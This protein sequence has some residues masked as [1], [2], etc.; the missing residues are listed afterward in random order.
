MRKWKNNEPFPLRRKKLYYFGIG[1]SFALAGLHYIMYGFLNIE[2]YVAI[3][4]SGFLI[5]CIQFGGAYKLARYF[6]ERKVKKSDNDFDPH[7]IK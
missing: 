6:A 7:W 4:L 1:G 2:N 5:Y 3:A